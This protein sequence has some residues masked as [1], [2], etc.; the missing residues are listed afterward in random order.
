MTDMK[1]AAHIV[2]LS[3]VLFSP[4]CNA[5]D[6]ESKATRFLATLNS[7]LKASAQFPF[8]DNERFNWHYVPRRRKGVSFHD[9]DAAQREAAK[10][11]LKASLSEQGYKKATDIIALEDILREVE[12]RDAGDSYR[13]YLNYY[14]SIFGTPSKEKPWGWRLEGHHISLN[15]SSVRGTIESST[16]SF[17][18]ANPAIVPEGKEKGK[19][20]LK[21]E[22]N[23]GF[24]LLNALDAEQKKTAIISEAAPSD[25]LTRNDRDA[26]E[27][28]PKGLSYSSLNEGQKKIF[29]Q[30]LDVYVKNYA[31]GFSSKLM[32]KIK[33]AGIDNLYFAWAG[34]LK[35]GAGHYYR[36]QGPMLVIEYDNIQNNANHIHTV[37]RDLT[38]DFAMD[39]LKEHYQSEHSK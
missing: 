38:N 9:L 31:F 23:L 8:E 36:I 25:I 7:K 15:F 6:L 4:V 34:S 2:I 14:F 3:T 29:M 5:Q 17:F 24:A 39:I 28:T 22:T 11:L 18:G 10:E 20:V 33:K 32:E 35:P 19:Q 12:G 27:L 1:I 37:V 21:L 30:L 26:K 13:D 16:P